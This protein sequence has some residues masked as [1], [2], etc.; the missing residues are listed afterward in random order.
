[1][2]PGSGPRPHRPS[3]T[4]VRGWCR[5]GAALEQQD[6][7]CCKCWTQATLTLPHSGRGL[8]IGTGAVLR[9]RARG[10]VYA[11]VRLSPNSTAP[12]PQLLRSMVLRPINL[13]LAARSFTCPHAQPPLTL[14]LP[15][16]PTHP[17]RSMVFGHND[18]P[19]QAALAPPPPTLHLLHLHR[20]PRSTAA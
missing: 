5:G 15:H 13:P 7:H 18:A 10:T 17:M 3:H 14:N 8:L 19:L 12:R 9:K 20:I 16:P 4:Q 6:A 1:M 11:G 2:Q